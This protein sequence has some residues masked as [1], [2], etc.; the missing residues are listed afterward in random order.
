VDNIEKIVIG[1]VLFALTSALGFLFKMRQL[2][3]VVPKLYRHSGL[4]VNGSLCEIIIY[5]RGKQ[6]EEDIQVVLDPDLKCELVAT[7]IPGIGLSNSSIELGRLHKSSNVSILI[8]VENG[9]F[10]ISKI[11]SISSKACSGRKVNRVFDVP[12]NWANLF[13]MYLASAAVLFVGFYGPPFYE[14]LD[15]KWSQS[16]LSTAANDGWNGLENFYHSSMRESY[17]LNEFPVRYI[18]RLTDKGRIVVTYEVYNKTS[19]PLTVYANAEVD[20]VDSSDKNYKDKIYPFF[21][22]VEVPPMEKK[23]FEAFAKMEFGSTEPLPITFLFK[24][25]EESFYKI[26]HRIPQEKKK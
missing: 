11:L 20:E 13:M 15:R 23:K 9:I 7:S 26:Q 8:L 18:S 3:V 10:D 5:N 21:S 16:R 12:S 19:L 22:S 17:S 2:Y 24:N 14:K 1:I 4:A 6:V 25:G